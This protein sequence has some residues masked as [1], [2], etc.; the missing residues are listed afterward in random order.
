[1]LGAEFSTAP[2]CGRHT[3]GKETGEQLERGRNL[4]SRAWCQ[5]PIWRSRVPSV[6]TSGVPGPFELPKEKDCLTESA[7]ER[8]LAISFASCKYPQQIPPSL[9]PLIHLVSGLWYLLPFGKAWTGKNNEINLL[10]R[11]GLET[12]LYV[13]VGNIK[14]ICKIT[15]PSHLLGGQAVRLRPLKFAPRNIRSRPQERKRGSQH[16][17]RLFLLGARITPAP[18]RAFLLSW[19]RRGRTPELAPTA[20]HPCAVRRRPEV[21]PGR[22]A[23]SARGNPRRERTA[24]ERRRLQHGVGAQLSALS[25]ALLLPA[26][27]TFSP[28]LCGHQAAEELCGQHRRGPPARAPLAAPGALGFLPG[29]SGVISTA[30]QPAGGHGAVREP[31][32]DS[33]SILPPHGCRGSRARL[34][35]LVGRCF[36]LDLRH[37]KSWSTASGWC[38]EDRSFSY[39][40]LTGNPARRGWNNRRW[41]FSAMQY[42]WCTKI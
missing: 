20:R 28:A 29:A 24:T 40:R 16:S 13:R 31:S 1:M 12:S 3:A 23:S 22:R 5:N 30:R 11:E 7:L 9:S 18:W 17:G 41:K 25:G 6:V 4:G 39:R 8:Y 14:I 27:L 10:R 35:C 2:H 42:H 19:G 32:W 36:F 34:G 21:G 15:S 37:H 33:A 26:L 38:A